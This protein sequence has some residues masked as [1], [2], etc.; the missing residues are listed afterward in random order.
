MRRLIFVFVIIHSCII[1]KAQDQIQFV[2]TDEDKA[3]VTNVKCGANNPSG[4]VFRFG[5]GLADFGEYPWM[6]AI[7]KISDT[8]STQWSDK[9]YLSAGTLIHPS[10]VLTSSYGYEKIK[11]NELKCRAGEWNK[12][13]EDE[14]YLHQE[15]NVRRIVTHKDYFKD[16]FYN[17]VTLMFLEKP[18]DLNE[19]PHVGAACAGQALPEPGT[20]CFG[21]GWGNG[22]FTNESDILKKIPVNLLSVADCETKMRETRLG[23]IF[24]LHESLTCASSADDTCKTE[25]G[26]PLVCPVKGES[27]RYV[28]YGLSAYRIQQDGAPCAYVNVPAFYS[29]IGERMAEEGFKSDSYT[30]VP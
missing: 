30:Y 29:W 18:F 3:T 26:A 11:P 13:A 17:A 4:L 15:R 2:K 24:R 28:L 16:S 10:V 8:S 5:N 27:T 14:N 22:A 12:K 6:V 25:V 9:D 1:S 7:I 20:Q 21:T 19:A 23:E